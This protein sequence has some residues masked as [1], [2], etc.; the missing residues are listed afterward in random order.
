MC[1]D[2]DLEVGSGDTTVE[3][4]T[5]AVRLVTGS[6]NIELADV[7]GNVS[8]STGP[9][10]VTAKDLRGATTQIEVSSGN[11]QLRPLGTGV[12][13]PMAEPGMAIN[14]RVP[15]RDHALQG[16][17]PAAATRTL[18]AKPERRAVPGCWTCARSSGNGDASAPS[19]R[20]F[21][22]APCC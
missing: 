16:Q 17:L 18:N 12:D 4:A 9:G 21:C 10:D 14:V 1:L 19:C 6:G 8:I 3:G 20:P 11:I 22:P 7:G 2:V 13:R 5:G 15:G